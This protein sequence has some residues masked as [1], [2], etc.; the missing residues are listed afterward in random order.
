M[1]SFIS[2]IICTYNRSKLLVDCL[3][4]LLR[5]LGSQDHYEII[6]V[7][8]NST[9]N[10]ASIGL[11]YSEKYEFVKYFKEPEV[12]L[13]H[14]RNA[15]CENANGEWLVYIDDD[16]TVDQKFYHELEKI[17]LINSFDLFTGIPIPNF[18]VQKPKWIPISFE[19]KMTRHTE[20]G[21]IENE[22]IVGCIMAIK[23]STLEKIG[24]FS[25]ALGMKGNQIAYG[26]D[27]YIQIKATEMNF[28]IGINPNLIVHHNVRKEKLKLKWHLKSE[29]AHG[30]A[31]YYINKR[32]GILKKTIFI[33]SF[34]SIKH[35]F[36]GCYKL[37]FNSCYYW[38]NYILDVVGP[39]LYMIGMSKQ[40]TKRK[41]S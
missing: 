40:F 29:F 13:S 26:E 25:P 32:K 33:H 28:K 31:G 6:I 23:K 20:I 17:I 30:K 5:N 11:K 12:G 34:L 24:G 18:E 21:L 15:G 1:D 38:Q 22:S 4:S 19:R 35:V 2:I 7:D 39:I 8:N 36:L 27:D 9:D 10:T 14:A 16:I 41:S 37:I 3:E